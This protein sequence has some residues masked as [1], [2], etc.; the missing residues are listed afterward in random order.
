MPDAWLHGTGTVGL[1]TNMNAMVH[2]VVGAVA[3]AVKRLGWTFLA[4]DVVALANGKQ[5][6]VM[7][8]SVMMLKLYA[9]RVVHDD[10][11]AKRSWCQTLGGG[12][13]QTSVRS[14]MYASPPGSGGPLLPRR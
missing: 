13:Y 14:R 11:A 4:F 2:N 12:A 8:I 1:A 3:Q 10:M 7:D 6:L 5:L 9:D